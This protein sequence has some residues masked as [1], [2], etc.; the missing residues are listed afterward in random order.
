ME[1]WCVVAWSVRD[2]VSWERT[3]AYRGGHRKISAALGVR[4]VEVCAAGERAE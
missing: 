1:S 2:V 3:Q 4:R